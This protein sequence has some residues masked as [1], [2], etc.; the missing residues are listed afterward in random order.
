MDNHTKQ[1]ANPND[2]DTFKKL[3]NES[4][5]MRDFITKIILESITSNPIMANNKMKG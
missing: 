4:E 1:T 5:Q 2:I 3:L